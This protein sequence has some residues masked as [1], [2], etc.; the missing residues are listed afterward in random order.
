M[1]RDHA[2]ATMQSN[3]GGN[4]HVYWLVDGDRQPPAAQCAD[5]TERRTLAYI[6]KRRALPYGD[7]CRQLG[8]DIGLW[9]QGDDLPRRYGAIKN[10]TR[11]VIK[12]YQSAHGMTMA[13]SS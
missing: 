2:V 1:N 7:I 10:M 11:D 9:Q 3:A 13:L 12:G 8:S 5:V 4:S 6:Q